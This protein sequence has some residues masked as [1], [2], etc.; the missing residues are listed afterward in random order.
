M[1]SK[2]FLGLATAALLCAG[3]ATRA[4]AANSVD[5]AVT[6]GLNQP[7]DVVV[8]SD[9][10][11][12]V[13]DSGSHRILKVPSGFSTFTVL[14]G[15]GTAGFANGN[16][17]AAKFNLP[18]GIV[19][20]P[21]V[22][23]EGVIVAD[24]GNHVIRFVSLNGAVS[25]LAG[26]P[27]SAGHSNGP[28]ATAK[29]RYPAGLAVYATGNIYVADSQ[30]NAIRKIDT[31][32]IVTTIA[33]AADGLFQPGALTIAPNG[34]VWVSDTRNHCIRKIDGDGNVTLIAGTPGLS[35]ATDSVIPTEAQF[36][37]PRGLTFLGNSSDV[38]ICDSAN[39]SIRRLYYDTNFNSYAVET[40]AGVLSQAGRVDGPALNA[41]F[42]FPIGIS[43]D[44]YNGGFLVSDKVNNLLRRIS[45]G[46]VQP[47]VRDPVIGWVDVITDP[48]TLQQVMVLRPVQSG[49]FNNEVVIATPT[50]A[51]TQ[52]F[53]T[54]GDTPDNPFEDSIPAPAP[55]VG[56]NAPMY[57][58]YTSPA[59][60]PVSLVSSRPDV[61][62][63]AIGVAEGRRSSAITVSRFIFR[64][65]NPNIVGE[66]AASFRVENITRDAQMWYTW[67][68]SEPTNNPAFSHGPVNSGEFIS[69][70]LQNT[71]RTFKIKA[72][73]P[74]FKT[75]DTI[76]KVFS[77]TNFVANDITFGFEH[78][79]ASSEFIASA[80]QRFYA[81][82][83]LSLLPGQRIYSLQ[84]NLSVTNESGPAVNGSSNDF[85][86][87]LLKKVTIGENHLSELG[88]KFLTIPPMHFLYESNGIDYFAS[89]LLNNASENLLLVGWLE[90]FGYDHLYDTKQHDLVKFSTAH[91]NVFLS[92]NGKVVAGA[93]SFAVPANAAPG[94]TYKIQIGR[95]SATSD[96]VSKNVYI[97]VPTNGSLTTGAPNGTKRV[98]IGSRRYIVGDCAPFRWFNAG[99]FGDTN[100]LNNDVL[101]VF[102]SVIYGI[103][104]P[105]KGSDFFDSM[106]SSDGSVFDLE[107]G[108]INSITGGDGELGVDDIFVTFRRSLDPSLRWYARYWSNGVRHVMQVPNGAPKNGKVPPASNAKSLPLA[109]RPAAVLSVQDLIAS[110]GQVVQVPVRVRV[111]G[112][113]PMRVVG[114]GLRVEALEG[115]PDLAEQ[116]NFSAPV[117]LGSPSIQS[118]LSTNHIGLAWLNNTVAGL[119]GDTLLGTL[120]FRIPS[121]ANSNAAYRIHVNHFSASDNGLRLFQT[122]THAG[123]VTLRDR[124]GSSLEDGVS[125]SWRLRHFRSASTGFG[126][127]HIDADYDGVS[128]AAEFKA[129]SNPTDPNSLLRLRSVQLSNGGVKLSFPTGLDRSYVI[130]CAPEIAGPWTVLST[131]TGTGGTSEYTNEAP[132]SGRRFYRV[133]AQ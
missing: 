110:P 89:L 82:V 124:S 47:P 20:S 86:S 71:N 33:D 28:A 13:T 18:Q 10:T 35:G 130:E 93:Y 119:V 81:P 101:Q 62:I 109:A 117:E 5:S 96:G 128:N 51:G 99:D 38:L 45:T 73:K 126:L 129:G 58:D 95:P 42:N 91:D 37:S 115:A 26:V 113:V 133:R 7:Y 59:F 98:V 68:G 79:E 52:T 107:A 22:R 77:P 90:R 14:A 65:A 72:F 108:D 75:S 132:G 54:F 106:D 44:L 78:G 46:P 31:N 40:F 84:F 48:V 67:D 2:F 43:R 60:M 41:K 83:T 122:T 4:T 66:N 94:N 61:T 105:P 76:T 131:N 39:H 8:T 23:G 56:F 19:L 120:S 3:L 30:N 12:Y 1:K 53:Y 74:N 111:S 102:Q 64:T 11:A 17:P 104:L 50:E 15:Q 112:G 114:L 16:G 49:V 24:Y 34:E 27:N 100:L 116:I 25:V 88:E 70:D 36:S 85:T 103:N 125:D 97:A 118:K 87:K 63:K 21:R 6:N 127:A 80:G 121:G 57:R 69:F 29:F 123:L 55:G 9:G 92:D 32:N